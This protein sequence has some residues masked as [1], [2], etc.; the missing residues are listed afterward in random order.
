MDFSKKII[1]GTANF[2]DSYGI[3]NNK[4]PRKKIGPIL[5]YAYKKKIIFLDV[6][7]DY[8]SSKL[9]KLNKYKNFKIY[10]KINIDDNFFSKGNLEKKINA[11]LFGNK[12]TKPK[13]YAV[14]IRK[15]KKYNSLKLKKIISFLQIL[16]KSY[17][18]EKIGISIYDVKNLKKILNK[19]KIDYIQLPYN[20][21]DFNT[22][23]LTKKIV[24]KRKIEIHLRSIFLQGLL[25]KNKDQIPKKLKKLKKYWNKIER[26]LE[27]NGINKITACVSYALR[28][29][30][31]KIIIGIDSK[32]QLDEILKIK[33]KKFKIA[34]LN[35]IEKKLIDPIFWLKFKTR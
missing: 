11:Y 27:I 34:K 8:K 2:D 16:K 17:K 7:K 5:N 1:L 31:D 35:I 3:F 26:I 15:P 20:I 28:A 32:N 23:K 13:C 10:K 14:T 30:P 19:F 4:I 29:K 9:E 18:I 22:L 21:L 24:K 33:A 25:L 12:N 6:A